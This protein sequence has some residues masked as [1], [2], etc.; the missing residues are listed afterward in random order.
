M[1]S[2][3]S[4]SPPNRSMTSSASPKATVIPSPGARPVEPRRPRHRRRHRRRHLHHHRHRRRALRGSVD[5][6]FLHP[7]GPR[8]RSRRAVLRRVRDAHPG[9]GI[10]LYLRLRDARRDLR[11]DHRL[12][13]DPGVRLQR[14]DRRLRMERQRGEPS[15]GLRDPP[16]PALHRHS[17]ARSWCSFRIGGSRSSRS[18]RRSLRPAP[19]RLPFRRSPRSSTSPLS[20]RCSR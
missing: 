4:S 19:I 7:R 15:P 2:C 12:G 20:S 5:R 11:L 18:G 17:R 10:R 9:R 13:L 16:S 8:V 1:H 14:G 3:P 6:A